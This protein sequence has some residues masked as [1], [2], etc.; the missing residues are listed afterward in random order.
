M[1][2]F[3]TLE[4][5]RAEILRLNEELATRTTERDNYSTRVTELTRENESVRELNQQYFLKLSAQYKPNTDDEDGDEEEEVLSCE[6][7]ARTLTI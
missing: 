6:D 4:E 2:E 5:A 7:F 3:N 1:P